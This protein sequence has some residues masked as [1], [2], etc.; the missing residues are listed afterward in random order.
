MN[1]FVSLSAGLSSLV[2][3]DEGMA[4]VEKLLDDARLVTPVGA[5]GVGKTRLAVQ[6]GW[7]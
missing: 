1:T 3:G 2:G 6:V 5:G 4:A 7:P